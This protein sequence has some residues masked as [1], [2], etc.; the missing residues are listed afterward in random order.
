MRHRMP[1]AIRTDLAHGR[2]HIYAA[3]AAWVVG[4][5]VLMEAFFQ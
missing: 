2:L 1:Q 4:V 3:A 5:N